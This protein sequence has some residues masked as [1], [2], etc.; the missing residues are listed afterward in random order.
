[1]MVKKL[2]QKY[3]QIDKYLGYFWPQKI[4]TQDV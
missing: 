4:A 2:P 3:T 1:M